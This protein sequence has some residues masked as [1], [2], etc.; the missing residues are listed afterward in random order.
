MAIFWPFQIYTSLFGKNCQKKFQT[1]IF[2]HSKF[3]PVFLQ[4]IVGKNS[5]QPFL[6]IPN[7]YQSFWEKLSE[8]IWN[9]HF[10]PFQ[11]YTRLSGKNWWKKAIF[12]HS[13]FIRVFWEKLMEKIQNGHFWP[14][15]IYTTLLGKNWWKKFRTAIFDHSQFI[16]VFLGKFVRKN[17]EQQ[18]LAI[19]N[20]Y[21]SFWEKLM[22]KI[23][24]SHFWP[25][26]IYTSLFGKNWWKKFRTAIFGHSEFVP[27]FLGKIDGKNSEWPFLAIPNLYQS[28]WETLS[29]KFQNSHFWSFQI[30]T[31]LF[32]KNCQKKFQTT[33][34]SH[35][36]FSHF[37]FIPVFLEKNCQKKFGTAIFGHCK[38]IPVFLEK[39]CQK[40]FQTAIFGKNCW[41]KFRMAIFCLSKFLPLFWGKIDGKNSEQ[42]FLTIPNLYQTFWEKLMEES[43]FWPFW[44]Y[45]S[46]FGKNWWKKF[47]TAIFGH[48]KFIP[49][50][51]G[52]IV[53][54][55]SE[56]PFLAIPNLYQ[57]FWEKLSEKISNSQFWPFPIYTSLL[58]KH[59]W[60]NSD[61]PYLAIL[62]LYQSFWEKL[63]EKFR[64]A[65]LGHSKFVPV[66]F[67][68]N[69]Q[70][71]FGMAIFGH[72]KFFL[73]IFLHIS[74]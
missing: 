6:T 57:T 7:L 10:W 66:F 14:F 23:W 53:R 65:I 26:W 36:K 69:C 74:L 73:T 8:K 22:E 24:N 50:F 45:T 11:I 5:E 29:E 28:C 52:K 25:F 54:K 59:Y 17:L 56:Q 34:F 32:G 39:N 49:L 61:Q 12:G 51:S 62:N 44:I 70:K 33:I 68:G 64:M 72:S 1:S 67:G 4:K 48:S 21:Q 47:R 9:G 27:V 35:F 19:A 58:R 31:S 41:K 38:F 43:H 30:Y 46:L 63:S 40:K 20:L 71:K 13:E 15:Q 16:P 37:Q 18:F 3:I 42:P 55:I 2:G 60:K